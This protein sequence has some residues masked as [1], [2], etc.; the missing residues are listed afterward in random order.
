L[1]LT[2]VFVDGLQQPFGFFATQLAR[3]RL[4]F[5]R[6]RLLLRLILLARLR[7]RLVVRFLLVIRLFPLR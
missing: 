3:L 7:C 2:G 4:W 5:T 6:F 1:N